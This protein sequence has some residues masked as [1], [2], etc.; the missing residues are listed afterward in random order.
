[1]IAF[2]AS[3]QRR[4]HLLAGPAIQKCFRRQ[5]KVWNGARFSR[6]T[7]SGLRTAGLRARWFDDRFTVSFGGLEEPEDFATRAEAFAKLK[8]LGVV[9]AVDAARLLQL[10]L[11][12]RD[13]A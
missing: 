7:V 13:G 6:R 4:N 3:N 11:P 1:M 2:D 8:P 9:S 5:V 12:R 10:P